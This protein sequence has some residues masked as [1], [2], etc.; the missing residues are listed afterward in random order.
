MKSD[1]VFN[2]IRTIFFCQ[3][4]IIQIVGYGPTRLKKNFRR[5]AGGR[6]PEKKNYRSNFHGVIGYG[7]TKLKRKFRRWAGGRDP[8]KKKYR[9]NLD[10]I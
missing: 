3:K 2:I 8:E 6:D 9:S 5:W 1:K 4:N 7:P 10:R